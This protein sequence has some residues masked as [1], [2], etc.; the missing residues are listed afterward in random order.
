VPDQSLQPESTPSA[1]EQRQE[2]GNPSDVTGNSPEDVQPSAA[3]A[4]A[5]EASEGEQVQADATINQDPTVGTTNAATEDITSNSGSDAGTKT[6]DTA[7]G[8]TATDDYDNED[9][10]HYRDLQREAKSRNLNAGGDR[11]ELVAKLREDDSQRAS[12]SPAASSDADA[13]ALDTEPVGTNEP[14]ADDVPRSEVPEEQVV[15]GGI[16][17]TDFSKEHSSVLQ[18]LSDERRDQQLS[19]A[20]ERAEG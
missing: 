9:A 15:N 19:A 20:R 5:P 17:R 11:E 2:P 1:V 4:N 10:W 6:G 13:E 7:T 3:R 16:N 8:G 14:P 18:G 12:G